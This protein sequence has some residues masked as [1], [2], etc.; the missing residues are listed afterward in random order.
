M[1]NGH[2]GFRSSTR[3]TGCRLGVEIEILIEILIEIVIRGRLGPL[4][5]DTDFDFDDDPVGVHL[6]GSEAS[7]I[8]KCLLSS[9]YTKVTR[10][11][12]VMG[13]AMH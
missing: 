11:C 7:Y 10:E 1:I 4:D 13:R 8:S 12:L 9:L 6:C 5:F 3:S 2:V